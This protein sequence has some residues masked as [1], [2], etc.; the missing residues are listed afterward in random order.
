MAMAVQVQVQVH[1]SAAWAGA[2]RC[3]GRKFSA[4]LFSFSK[5]RF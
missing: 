2:V 1:G 4:A 5:L 3:A